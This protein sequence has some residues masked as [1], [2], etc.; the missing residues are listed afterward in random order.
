MSE[1]SDITSNHNFDIISAEVAKA[2][3]ELPIE[4]T[5]GAD[6]APEETA[7]KPPKETKPPKPEKTDE[8]KPFEVGDAEI[9]RA[10]KAGMTIADAR[11]F[12][13]KGAFERICSIL[14][15]KGA[16]QPPD[17]GEKEISKDSG[18]KD[19]EDEAGSPFDFDV[20]ELTE[21]EEY[22]PKVV[23]L[24]A[25]VRQM[26]DALKKLGKENSSLRERIGKS[27]EAEREAAKEAEKAKKLEDRK[28]LRI[29]QP[30]G[31]RGQRK[32]KSED[33]ILAEVASDISSK[34]NI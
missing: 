3:N 25:V 4:V 6:K 16:T 13:D 10:V 18:K 33:D 34:F 30:G 21:D 20:P 19:D 1:K 28:N 9:E 24:S 15:A 29:A 2:V 14:E 23:K 26:G 5:D 27:E 12:K 7:Q 31:V 8:D 32:E 11:S 22:D 17:G